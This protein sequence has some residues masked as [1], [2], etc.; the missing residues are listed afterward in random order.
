[1]AQLDELMNFPDFTEDLKICARCGF[2]KDVCPTFKF[3][4]GF[5]S[6]SPRGRLYFLPRI[7]RWARENDS[8]MGRQ[9]LPLYFL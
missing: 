4:D 1:M 2:C 5:E 9:A 6:Y 3:S 7:S 8:R